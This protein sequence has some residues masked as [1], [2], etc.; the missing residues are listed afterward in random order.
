MDNELT[1]EQL[2]EIRERRSK[3]TKGEWSGMIK[4]PNKPDR[5]TFMVGIL[6]SEEQKLW[7]EKTIAEVNGH[8]EQASHDNDFI[9][10]APQDIDALLSHIAAQDAKQQGQ[11]SNL[12]PLKFHTVECA[13]LGTK[14]R[15]IVEEDGRLYAVQVPVQ[16]AEAFCAD[17]MLYSNTTSRVERLRG[18][19]LEREHECLYQGMPTDAA[20]GA[21]QGGEDGE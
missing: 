14:W 4:N 18:R 7:L 20:P 8:D 21:G 2:E 1:A 5:R 13:T 3:A 11:P 17:P 19:M 9:A 12:Y 10:H 15:D 16:V 6:S